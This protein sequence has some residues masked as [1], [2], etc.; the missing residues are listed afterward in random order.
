[1]SNSKTIFF[2]KNYFEYNVLIFQVFP[3]IFS[4]LPPPKLELFDLDEAFSSQ[5]TQINQLTNKIL[6]S[7]EEK[8]SKNNINNKELEFYIK[9][10]AKTL[11]IILD[12]QNNNTKEILYNI[13][14]K[15]AQYKKSDR[16]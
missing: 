13:G 11:G 7:I 3:P 2:K 6:T 8:H 10:C 1:M 4:E 5:A 12:P 14:I 15:I 9:E 16:E